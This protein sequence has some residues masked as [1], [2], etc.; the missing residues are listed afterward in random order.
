[1]ILFIGLYTID[2]SSPNLDGFYGGLWVDGGFIFTVLVIV[3][4]VKILISSYL[5][6]FWA[7][8]W[9][10]ASVAFYFVCF[11]M[12][13]TIFPESN[14]YAA[15]QNMLTFPETY[16]SF[17][18]FCSAFVLIDSGLHY[19]GIE[20]QAWQTRRIDKYLADQKA[21]AAKDV[22]SIRRK[23]TLFKSKQTPSLCFNSLFSI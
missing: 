22:T 3:A 9:V 23:V 1:M 16:F 4:N 6:T 14:D 19:L 18:F 13:S 12:T 20:L 7:L 21:K 11:V 5:I 2:Q 10:V 15:F 8:L 17:L